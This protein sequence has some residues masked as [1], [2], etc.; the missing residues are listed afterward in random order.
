MLSLTVMLM[1]IGCSM[2]VPTQQAL[3]IYTDQSKARIFVNGR[4][5]GTGSTVTYVPRNEYV[6]IRAK[7]DGYEDSFTSI[8]S[9]LNVAGILDIIGIFFYIL[10]AIGLAFPGSRSLDIGTVALN[11]IEKK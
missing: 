8:G 3:T 7:A 9:H 6:S 2:F 11:M 1:G 4:L 10:P 5:V